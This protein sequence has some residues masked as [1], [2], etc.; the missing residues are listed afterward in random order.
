MGLVPPGHSTA[1]GK[2]SWKS[3][4]LELWGW[5]PAPRDGT[6]LI[7]WRGDLPFPFCCRC[8]FQREAEPDIPLAA[9]LRSL[10]GLLGSGRNPQS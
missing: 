8:F 5:L 2:F 3:H 7:R 10:P 1:P 9:Q 6:T 4:P